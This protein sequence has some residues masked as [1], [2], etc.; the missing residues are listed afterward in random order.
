VFRD[1]LR[2]SLQEL[3][4]AATQTGL[5][6]IEEIDAPTHDGSIKETTLAY[7]SGHVSAVLSGAR[8]TLEAF[9]ECVEQEDARRRS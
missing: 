1:K 9:E 6:I 8:R 5:L 7:V 3:E 4:T 2:E